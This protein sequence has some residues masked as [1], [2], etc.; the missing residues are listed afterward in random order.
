M[1]LIINAQEIEK[2]PSSLNDANNPIQ[3]PAI[4]I[5]PNPA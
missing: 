4:I 5:N 2:S 3:K 1:K